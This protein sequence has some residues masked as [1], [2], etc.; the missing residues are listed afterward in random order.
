M[1]QPTNDWKQR[2]LRIERKGKVFEM[3]ALAIADSYRMTCPVVR[4]AKIDDG[5]SEVVKELTKKEKGEGG[6]WLIC[7]LRGWKWKK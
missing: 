4:V 3:K 1:T 2:V 6:R 5:E 7:W